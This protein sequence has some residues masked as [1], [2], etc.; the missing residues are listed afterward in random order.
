MHSGVESIGRFKAMK[1]LRSAVACRVL[2]KEDIHRR[3]T[4]K[5]IPKACVG[6]IDSG[7]MA[8]M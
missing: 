8:E 5:F 6:I 7:S 3:N 1:S 4:Q 2:N